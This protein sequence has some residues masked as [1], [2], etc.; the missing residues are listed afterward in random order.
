MNSKQ[1]ADLMDQQI[2]DNNARRAQRF[3]VC[4]ERP[5]YS[6][7]PTKCSISRTSLERCA[8]QLGPSFV[9]NLYVHPIRL[10]EAR[11]RARECIAL[12]INNPFAPYI[13]IVETPEFDEG[14]WCLEANGQRVGSGAW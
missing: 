6:P 12:A 11:N 4:H 14:E 9:Y 7:L 2:A 13:N 5:E 8:L 3:E 1:R 10:L